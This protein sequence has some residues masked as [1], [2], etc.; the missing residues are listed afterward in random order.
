MYTATVMCIGT[1]AHC[2]YI[3]IYILHRVILRESLLLFVYYCFFGKRKTSDFF[4][5][6]RRVFFRRIPRTP[7]SLAAGRMTR[8]R[9]LL[10]RVFICVY[11]S[12]LR[13]TPSNS[14]P[15]RHEHV[16]IVV[17]RGIQKRDIMYII[18]IFL[19]FSS[20]HVG[21]RENRPVSSLCAYDNIIIPIICKYY[22]YKTQL[23]NLAKNVI[24]ILR[25]RRSI[26]YINVN[27]FYLIISRRI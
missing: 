15:I 16:I 25:W 27:T 3:H 6:F 21:P 8:R 11:V 4:Y 26:R 13:I 1:A 22:T 9:S 19:K 14:E 10:S 7:K 18:Y 17:R 2:Y 24:F 20:V 23:P 5:R 12:S